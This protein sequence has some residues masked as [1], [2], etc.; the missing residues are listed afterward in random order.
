M[1]FVRDVEVRRLTFS[2]FYLHVSLDVLDW[3]CRDHPCSSDNFFHASV[4]A[5]KSRHGK[6]CISFLVWCV[7]VTIVLDRSDF[8]LSLNFH[9]I[10]S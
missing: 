8:F 2:C 7:T 9:Q 1:N 6:T 10:F 5:R 4:P 3:V